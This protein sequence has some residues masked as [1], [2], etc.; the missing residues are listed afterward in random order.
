MR[1]LNI[2]DQVSFPKIADNGILL[3]NQGSTG[4]CLVWWP[5]YGVCQE[6][7]KTLVCVG[8]AC[9][10]ELLLH[11]DEFVRKLGKK[12]SSQSSRTML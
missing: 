3:T 5:Q 9:I 1:D 4:A 7:W 10:E 2:G 11:E 6:N 8:P 12:L